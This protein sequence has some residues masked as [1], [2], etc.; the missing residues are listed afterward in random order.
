MKDLEKE[1]GGFTLIEL[2]VV[3]GIILLLAGM[4]FP[5]L[6]GARE[7]G[8]RAKCVNNLK[9]ISA[10]LHMYAADH[11]EQFPPNLQALIEGG[12]LDDINVFICPSSSLKQIDSAD[13]GSYL[14]NA[15]LT[16]S[17]PSTTPIVCDRPENHKGKG[18]N[19][20]YVGGTVKWSAGKNGKWQ[21]PF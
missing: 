18:G 12:Y 5:A 6:Q 7:Q 21:P 10:A 15:G 8:R 3:I 13:N 4:L 20:L 14:Y 11:N 2:L 19:V 16:E 9:Q 1:T 17:S